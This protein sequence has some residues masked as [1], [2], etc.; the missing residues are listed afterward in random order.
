MAEMTTVYEY[1]DKLL[2]KITRYRCTHIWIVSIALH[3]GEGE[4]ED[5]I[6]FVRWAHRLRH[7][8]IVDAR[9]DGASKADVRLD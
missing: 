9:R 3:P 5:D 1:Q 7:L 4:A 2:E 8:P 6:M